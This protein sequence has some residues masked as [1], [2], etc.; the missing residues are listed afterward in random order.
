LSEEVTMSI[1]AVCVPLASVEVSGAIFNPWYSLTVINMTSSDGTSRGPDLNVT[2]QCRVELPNI[3]LYFDPDRITFAGDPQRSSRSVNPLLYFMGF[4]TFLRYNVF[5]PPSSLD[6]AK[7]PATD[8]VPFS[9]ERVIPV[10]TVET[11]DGKQVTLLHH[12]TKGETLQVSR[13]ELSDF[14]RVLNPAL[15]YALGYYLRGCENRAYLLVEYY[16][17][18]E[19]IRHVF[20]GEAPFLDALKPFGVVREEYKTFAKT[21]NDIEVAPLDIGRHA[22]KPDAD[23]YEVDLRRMLVQPRSREVTEQATKLCRS[24]ID[25]YLRYLLAQS[26]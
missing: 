25:A 15:Y 6:P 19:A 11:V 8:C 20:G 23:V 3:T 10:E 14:L 22:P 1:P 18:V 24:V 4:R 21:S 16:K 7:Y 2:P 26:R 5:W 9:I 12:E 13:G 17:A